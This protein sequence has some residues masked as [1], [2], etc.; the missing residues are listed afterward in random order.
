MKIKKKLLAAPIL[1]MVFTLVGIVSTID[2]QVAAITIMI[3]FFSGTLVSV[4]GIAI[5]DYGSLIEYII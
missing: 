2:A 1:G 3:Y 5:G 4:A